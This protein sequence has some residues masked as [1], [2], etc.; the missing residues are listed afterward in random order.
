MKSRH[1][2]KNEEVGLALSCLHL[3]LEHWQ[4][5]ALAVDAKERQVRRDLEN[6]VSIE[7]PIGV[8]A[9][10]KLDHAPTG[11]PRLGPLPESSSDCQL[12]RAVPRHPQQQR[13]GARRPH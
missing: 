1:D 8:G 9:L 13:S 7:L 12:H 2:P 6:M 5:E 11:D 3:Q 10:T 4:E